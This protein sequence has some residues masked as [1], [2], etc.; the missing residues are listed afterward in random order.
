[1]CGAIAN[2]KGA[3]VRHPWAEYQPQDRFEEL[4]ER[5]GVEEQRLLEGDGGVAGIKIFAEDLTN[6]QG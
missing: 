2:G 4:N 1:V 5:E 3:Q 6:K